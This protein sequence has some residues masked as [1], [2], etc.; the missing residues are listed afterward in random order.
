VAEGPPEKTVKGRLKRP[1]STANLTDGGNGVD[2]YTYDVFGTVRSQSGSS[3]NPWLFTGEQVDSTGLQYLRARY[4]DP[5][6]GRFLSQ[7][8]L[9]AGKGGEGNG[10]Y[11][12]ERRPAKC[13]VATGPKGV[14][15][16]T[17]ILHYLRVR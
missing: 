6:I 8:P 7:D 16:G 9:G 3:D 10:H 13:A 2:A 12:S 4:Y 17:F 14:H 11:C 5:A 15:L 1:N